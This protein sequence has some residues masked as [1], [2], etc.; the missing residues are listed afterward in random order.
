MIGS[1]KSSIKKMGK[2]LIWYLP[3]SIIIAYHRISDTPNPYGISVS[4]ENFKEHIR[5]LKDFQTCTASEIFSKPLTKKIAITF[6]DGYVDIIPALEE[7]KRYSIKATVF[8]PTG[9]IGK[10]FWWD[11]L[12]E[13]FF[14]KFQKLEIEIDGSRYTFDV[15]CEVSKN[16]IIS[17]PKNFIL[18]QNYS[19]S[20][21]KF[22]QLSGNFPIL[23][24][25]YKIKKEELLTWLYFKLKYMRLPKIEEI[26]KSIKEQVRD[27]VKFPESRVMGEK[28]VKHLRKLGFEIGAH[29]VMHE[30]MSI[31]SEKEQEAEI[32]ES[33]N[34]LESLIGEK[35]YGFSYPF[36]LKEDF[37]QK[38]VS[39][40]KECGFDYACTGIKGVI[41]PHQIIFKIERFMLK[42]FMVMNWPKQ[43]FERKI[44]EFFTII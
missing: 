36:G 29:T 41:L 37:L 27:V 34:Y 2:K 14:S 10:K 9:L 38:T 11:E 43:I 13:I 26:I 4:P 28:D 1:I 12:S 32:R 23:S 20:P 35:I 8:I 30:V 40:V 21:T 24:G 7:L 31:L 18:S 42:R 39:K 25:R 16:F 3:S 22:H 19:L 33:K 17:L 44:K 6:D 15:Y 5:I